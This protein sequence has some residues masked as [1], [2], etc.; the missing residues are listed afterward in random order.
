MKKSMLVL[1]VLVTLLT[2]PAW[3][4]PCVSGSLA[5]YIALGSTG[6]SIGDKTFSNFSDTSSGNVTPPDATAITVTPINSTDIGLAFNALWSVSGT[7]L[8]SDSTIDFEVAV[9]GGGPMMITDASTVQSSSGFTG[10][11]SA[12][13]TEGICGPAPCTVT[14]EST[15]T[16]NSAGSTQL[17]NEVT[18]TPTGSINAVKDIGVSSGSS[19]S[20]SISAIQDTF[21]Q[22]PTSVPEPMSLLLLGTVLAGVGIVHRRTRSI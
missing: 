6:C 10:T 14:Q 4:A 20:A 17:S 8:T 3:S 13:V 21:S 11:G 1:G 19:G 18:F 22:T 7:N 5:S 15:S 12:S 2:A 16:I 9:I